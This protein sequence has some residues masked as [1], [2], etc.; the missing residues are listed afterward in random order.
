[1]LIKYYPQV[2]RNRPR[3]MIGLA[4]GIVVALWA[5]QVAFEAAFPGIRLVVYSGVRTYTEQEA[6]FRQR[7]V[8]AADINGRRVYDAR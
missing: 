3:T 7:Y 4:V 1:M 6:I 5:M 2:L 8:R